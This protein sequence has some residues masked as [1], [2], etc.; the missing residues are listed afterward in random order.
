MGIQSLHLNNYLQQNNFAA[1]VPV[2]NLGKK[3]EMKKPKMETAAFH[4]VILF[5]FLS[6]ELDR[7]WKWEKNFFLK[8]RGWR[9]GTSLPA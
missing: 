6:L 7:N 5:F 8:Y 9:V 4:S 3:F 1:L 2:K